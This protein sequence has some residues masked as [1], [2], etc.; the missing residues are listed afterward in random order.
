[1]PDVIAN[2]SVGTADNALYTHINACLHELVERGYSPL[3]VRCYRSGL[4][5][6][7]YWLNKKKLAWSEMNEAL[8]Q[9]FITAHLPVCDCTGRHQRDGTTLLAALNHLL[10]Y[11]RAH[12][13][14]TA[15]ATGKDTMEEEVRRY[16]AY[17]D[18]TCGL[19]FKSRQVRT[20]LIRRFL[21]ERFAHCSADLSIGE[22]REICEYVMRATQGW[23]RGSAA[24]LC[25]ALRSYLR[26]RAFQG[27]S[28][29]ALMAAVPTVALWPVESLPSV[30][31]AEEIE[32]FLGAFDC[33][34]VVGSRNYAIARC[35]VDLGLRAGEVAAL[36]IDDFNWHAGTLQLKR[37]KGKRIDTLP[38]PVVTGEAI[39]AYLTRRTT[40]RTERALFVRQ[41]APFDKPFTVEMV[42]YAMRQAYVRSGIA[43]PWGGT[44][45]LRHSLACR[46]VNA[47]VPIKEIADVLRHRSLNTTM[48]YAKV[49]VAHLATVAMPWPG[50]VS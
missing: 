32:R 36:A 42:S 1:M 47:G 2:Q 45:C 38:L 29:E 8:V 37:T 18:K 6:F 11:L 19:A 17:L 35:L 48:T 33:R 7:A 10:G 28:T 46:L 23:T 16:D 13:H 44:H 40:A 26:F 5:H 50:R 9:G 20:H 34:S 14:I 39:V 12:G 30:L 22:P 49:N 25:G 27:E 41:Q 21:A 15:K 31:T 43:K 24:V 4:A 3:T